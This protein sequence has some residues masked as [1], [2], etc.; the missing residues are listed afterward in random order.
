MSIAFIPVIWGKGTQPLGSNLGQAIEGSTHR[1]PDAHDPAHR[2]YCRQHMGCVGS[3]SASC[4]EEAALLEAGEQCF[5]EQ[6]FGIPLE[7]PR[8][9]LT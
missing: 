6:I 4:F 8:A 2:P 9:K 3:L 7:Q 1:L 5:G